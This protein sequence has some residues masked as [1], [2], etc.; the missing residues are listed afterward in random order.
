M[1]EINVELVRDAVRKLSIEANYFLGADIKEALEK[2]KNEETWKLAEDV[3]DKI[4][5]NSEIACN[6][7][8]PMCQDTGMACVFVEIGQDVHLIG[9]SLEDA[10]NEG[11]RRGYEEGFLRKSVVGDPIRRV[12]TK[13]NTPAVIYYD[14]TEG[15]KIKITLAPKG[16]GSENMSKIG[17]LKPS[18]GLEGVKKFII[19]T[20]KAAGPNP[21]PP[22]IIG[23][24]IGGT[25]DKAAYLAKKALLRPINI[26]NKDNFYEDL[27]NELL[28]KINELGIGP[29]GFGGRT[30]ALG[31]NIETYPTHIAGLPV[32]VNINCHATRHKE[33]VL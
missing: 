26:R 25:F 30:T 3:L 18:D 9:G 32:A 27:E 29:Q 23:V 5:I 17:M 12:N 6:E 1:R 24:G 8:M 22:M 33:V 19:D 10:I 14:I 7:E 16:F 28:I 21:C 2:A 4:I 13:D 20:V 31:L 11:V 15:D